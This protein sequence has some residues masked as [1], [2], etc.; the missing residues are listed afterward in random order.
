MNYAGSKRQSDFCDVLGYNCTNYCIPRS[1]KCAFTLFQ[2]YLQQYTGRF[3]KWRETRKLD[4][5]SR[6]STDRD[7][8]LLL[9]LQSADSAASP[10]FGRRPWCQLQPRNKDLVPS[11]KDGHVSAMTLG[12]SGDWKWDVASPL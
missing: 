3:H 4:C 11:H 10:V 6:N 7:A 8:H 9:V 2:T 5:F 12:D 1:G